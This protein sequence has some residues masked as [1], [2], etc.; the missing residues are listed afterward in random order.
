MTGLK[1]RSPAP[2]GA[3]MN[4]RG[5]HRDDASIAGMMLVVAVFVWLLWP[6][7]GAGAPPAPAPATG[8]VWPAV[9][10]TISTV[11]VVHPEDLDHER[12]G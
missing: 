3:F 5:R 10:R 4:P 1:G 6:R 11:V 9:T 7:V 8:S 12:T 2:A